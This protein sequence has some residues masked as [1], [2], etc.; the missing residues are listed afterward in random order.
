M[1]VHTLCQSGLHTPKQ[2]GL[3]PWG[4]R[5]FIPDRGWC[6]EENQRRERAS[7]QREQ[8]VGC[9]GGWC[10][11][12]CAEITRGKGL[13]AGEQP[14]PQLQGGEERP[15]QGSR[16]EAQRERK[17]AGW[18]AEAS[19]P[20]STCRPQGSSWVTQNSHAAF[21]CKRHVLCSVTML[22]FTFGRKQQQGAPPQRSV[23]CQT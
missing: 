9:G 12:V 1:R 11:R 16:E 13:Q 21:S 2:T 20:V 17:E 14:V 18:D 8:R 7:G 22:G 15:C 19:G 3:L 4:S 5:V 6:S 23:H 10:G